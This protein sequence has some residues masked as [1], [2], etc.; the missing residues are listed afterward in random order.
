MFVY[1]SVDSYALDQLATM[2]TL[3]RLW[4]LAELSRQRTIAAT[5]ASLNRTALAVSQ[6][7]ALSER[8]AGVPSLEGVPG[9]VRVTEVGRLSASRQTSS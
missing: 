3:H 1:A 7:V 2:L 6:Q 4:M 9:S 8:E 5:A